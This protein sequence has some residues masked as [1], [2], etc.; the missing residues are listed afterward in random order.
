MR[1]ADP[2]YDW[3]FARRIAGLVTQHGGTNS[4]MAIRAAELGL[5]SVIGCGEQN[6]ERWS[7]ARVVEIDCTHRVVRKVA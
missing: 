4:H 3:L 5:P 6:F 2:G 1:S 7:K